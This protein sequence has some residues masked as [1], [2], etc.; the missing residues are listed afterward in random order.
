MLCYALVFCA[1]VF[2]ALFCFAHK[3]NAKC[4]P[5]KP[6]S[7]FKF[8]WLE[9]KWQESEYGVFI[10]RG[11]WW[12]G[13]LQWYNHIIAAI[14]CVVHLI[15]VFPAG[16]KEATFSYATA[17]IVLACFTLNWLLFAHYNHDVLGLVSPAVVAHVPRVAKTYHPQ[18]Y[19]QAWPYPFLDKVFATWTGEVGLVVGILVG[20]AAILK[21][22]DYLLAYD[23]LRM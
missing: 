18:N 7:W 22:M 3:E 14:V 15:V 10:R 11:Y 8:N 5:C 19:K 17:C 13:P 16:Q 21:G 1:L 4:T 6:N 2:C 20:V 9:P 12:F 23:G